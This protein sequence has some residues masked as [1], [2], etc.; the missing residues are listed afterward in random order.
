MPRLFMREIHGLCVSPPVCNQ[1]HYP[2]QD[3]GDVRANPGT[4]A[5]ILQ[6]LEVGNKLQ[7]REASAF[8]IVQNVKDCGSVTI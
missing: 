4:A 6:L 8:R 5:R 2:G 1:L 7:E 3:S